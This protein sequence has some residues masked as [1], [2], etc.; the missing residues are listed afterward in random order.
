MPSFSS[1]SSCWIVKLLKLCFSDAQGLKFDVVVSNFDEDLDKSTFT[2]GAEYASATATHKAMEVATR[3]EK[4]KPAPFVVIGAD[5]VVEGP[6]G[7]ILEKPKDAD[8][9]MKMLLSLQGITH[10]VHTG[11]GVIFPNNG[12]GGERL[13]KTF[14][15]TTKVTFA[16]LGEAEIAAYIKT[17]E[18]FDKAG[19]YGARGCFYSSTHLSF[20]KTHRA[21]GFLRTLRASLTCPRLA[22]RSFVSQ[23]SKVPRELS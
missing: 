15:E 5:T 22:F 11:V 18:P 20:I 12:G 21:E 14:S 17:G 6:D 4:E 7:A 19:G 9:A 16:P 13:V 23:G 1:D 10:Q 3:L 8:E 2:G